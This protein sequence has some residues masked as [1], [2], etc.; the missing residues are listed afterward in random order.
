MAIRCAILLLW[1]TIGT[2]AQAQDCFYSQQTQYEDGSV[3][4]SIQRYDCKSPPET[5]IVE[6]VEEFPGHIA[7]S[8]DS[9]SEIVLPAFKNGEVALV[10]DI[11]SEELAT[12]DGTDHHYLNEVIKLIESVI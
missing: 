7:C 12:F 3:I 1:I 10:L 11:D 5:I 6:N 8:S 4:N 9:K 2:S